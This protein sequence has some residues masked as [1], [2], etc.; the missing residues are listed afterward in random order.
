M[1]ARYRAQV[2]LALVTI[3][4]VWGS[5]FI[6]LAI[7]VRDLPPFLS[8]ALRHLDRGRGAPRLGAAAR[9]PRG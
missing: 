2:W 5:T 3:Y 4:I 6:A 7:V 8:M 1:A 9:R